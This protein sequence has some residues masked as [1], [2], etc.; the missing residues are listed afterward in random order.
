MRNKDLLILVL[1]MM[2]VFGFMIP[3][4]SA[5]VDNKAAT[6]KLDKQY[7]KVY[8]GGIARSMAEELRLSDEDAGKL[9]DYVNYGGRNW[10]KT[11]MG[12][13]AEK[14]DRMYIV[15]VSPEQLFWIPAAANQDG[16]LDVL[17][18]TTAAEDETAKEEVYSTLVKANAAS[19]L[20]ALL[21]KYK[22]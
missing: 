11:E 2:F 19:P 4:L 9:M 13:Y 14:L 16:S 5:D 3:R 1:V 12:E 15:Q 21:E 8:Y 10:T 6:P 18:I 22:P 17:F 20:L 7:V